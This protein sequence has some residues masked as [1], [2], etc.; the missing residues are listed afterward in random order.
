MISYLPQAY[1]GAFRRLVNFDE[2]NI[3]R[4]TRG[5]CRR[6]AS[7]ALSRLSI[8][9]MAGWIFAMCKGRN[10]GRDMHGELVVMGGMLP[11]RMKAVG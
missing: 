6:R 8:V 2:R 1:E 7:A 10:V 5:I 9:K 3:Q 4:S 11:V